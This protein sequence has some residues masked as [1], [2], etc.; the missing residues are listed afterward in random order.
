MSAL[1]F[2]FLRYCLVACFFLFDTPSLIAQG[3]GSFSTQTPGWT[4]HLSERYESRYSSSGY[5]RESIERPPSSFMVKETP[6][7]SNVLSWKERKKLRKGARVY[8][9]GDDKAKKRKY[10]KAIK[11]FSKSL[12]N[13]IF[14]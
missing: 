9:R 7:D 4:F 12:K 8:N 2:H 13:S 6:H 10:K 5:Q 14:S 3:L 11:K 1:L